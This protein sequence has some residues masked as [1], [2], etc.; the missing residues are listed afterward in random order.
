MGIL[1]ANAI[2]QVE[3]KW[4]LK[5]EYLW[6]TNKLLETKLYCR[7]L[8]KRIKIR[9]VLIVRHSGSFSKWTREELQQMDRRTRKQMTMHSREDVDRRCA[10]KRR[11]RLT[12]IEDIVDASIHRPKDYTQKRGGRLITTTRSNTENMRTNRTK[13]T[14]KNG[15]KNSSMDVL[16]DISHKKTWT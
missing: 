12:S 16:S 8:I 11:K 5:K 2:K 6:R 13:I 14:R 1:E 3:M 9:T 10:K 7:N 4:K 15:K